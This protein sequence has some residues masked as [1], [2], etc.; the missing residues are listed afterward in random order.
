MEKEDQKLLELAICGYLPYGLKCHLMGMAEDDYADPIIPTIHKITGFLTD[1]SVV[2]DNG[3]YT[4]WELDEVFPILYPIEYLTK[5]I[6]VEGYNDGKEFV[7]IEELANIAYGIDYEFDTI[8]NH[9]NMHVCRN[10]CNSFVY[11]EVAKHFYSVKVWDGGT[12]ENLSIQ[13]DLFD[14]MNQ[15][16]ID[17][18]GLIAKGLAVDKTTAL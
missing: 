12:V 1:G 2:V 9:G 10:Q 6:T 13:A 5:P 11:N 14:L 3:K 16:H 4:P 17:W 7:P 15:W 18:R 8:I